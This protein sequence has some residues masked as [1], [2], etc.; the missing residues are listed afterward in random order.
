MAV[1]WLSRE[2]S[3]TSV[4]DVTIDRQLVGFIS[5]SAVLALSV[6]LL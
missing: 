3:I 5:N 4:A 1:H 6:I 2:I